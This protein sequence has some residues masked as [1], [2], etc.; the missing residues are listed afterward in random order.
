[1]W[2]QELSFE[3]DWWK[4]KK[5]DAIWQYQV[6]GKSSTLGSFEGLAPPQAAGSRKAPANQTCS[7][8]IPDYISSSIWFKFWRSISIINYFEVFCSAQGN[9]PMCKIPPV[10]HRRRSDCGGRCWWR[11]TGSARGRRWGPARG[12]E[13]GHCDEE[14]QTEQDKESKKDKLKR[15]GCIRM[16]N[17]TRAWWL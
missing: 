2:K 17:M 16:N 3:A 4:Q 14:G 8:S 10:V 11:R 5:I 7:T 15:I 1:M 6:L 9:F 13:Q 12:D